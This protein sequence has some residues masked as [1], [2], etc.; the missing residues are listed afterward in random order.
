MILESYPSRE[1]SDVLIHH[2]FTHNTNPQQ[3]L[4]LLVFSFS[5]FLLN[6]LL[7]A[8][9]TTMMQ[10]WKIDLLLLCKFTFSPI[11]LWGPHAKSTYD[12][13]RVK[14]ELYFISYG[15]F[16]IQEQICNFCNFYEL[17]VF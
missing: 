2:F 16:C 13:F 9:R 15:Q 7:L 6:F 10:P 4:L 1:S 12:S 17:R 11:I 3:F 14:I 5:F 8:T